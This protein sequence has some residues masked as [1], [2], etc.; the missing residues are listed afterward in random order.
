MVRVHFHASWPR[1]AR[2]NVQGG[3]R[4]L[5]FPAQYLF[6]HNFEV[7]NSY[8]IHQEVSNSLGVSLSNIFSN[9]AASATS[10]AL[11]CRFGIMLRQM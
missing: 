3:E 7:F 1:N 6:H 11:R 5:Q 2:C 8:D 4:V 10:R 9:G